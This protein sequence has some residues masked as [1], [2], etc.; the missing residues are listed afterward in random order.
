MNKID[1]S[2]VNDSR[3]K[4]SDFPKSGFDLS[5]NHYRDFI[6]GHLMPAGYQY[7]MPAD[8]FQ[9]SNST[10]YTFNTLV[11]PEIS[12]VQVSQHNF[13]VPF[14]AIDNS[15][16][17]A[18]VPDELNNMSA[19]WRTPL[20]TF[21]QI[22]A[23][24]LTDTPLESFILQYAR[25][26]IPGDRNYQ[27]SDQDELDAVVATFDAWFDSIITNFEFVYAVPFSLQWKEY[28]HNTLLTMPLN[29]A[30]NLDTWVSQVS[31][32][33]DAFLR[34]IIGKG[35]LLDSLGYIYLR[36]YDLPRW[37]SEVYAATVGDGT[38]ASVA[39]F[40]VDLDSTPMC[41]YALRAYYA[42]WYEHYRDPYLQKRSANLPDW[43]DFSSAAIMSDIDMTVPETLYLLLPRIRSWQKDIFVGSMPDDISRHVYA[44]IIYSSHDELVLSDSS[45]YLNA[46]SN[47]SSAP[48]PS[49][50]GLVN[51][52]SYQL[53][54]H[55]P[56]TGSDKSISCP[57]P[58]AVNDSLSTL[59]AN[60]YTA[61][62]FA[63][64]LRDLRKS[65]M[66]ER[67]LK[68]NFYFGDEYQDRMLA[69]YGSKV[70][71][72]SIRR[73]HLLSSS[74][75]TL[76]PKQEVANM[77]NEQTLA[78]TRIATAQDNAGGDAY[79]F[80]A[81]EFGIVINIVSV[82]PKAQYA[83]VCPQNML[84]QQT[85]FPI[86]EFA[87]NNDEFGRNLEIAFSCVL[88]GQQQ[89]QFG[90]YPYAH[91][92]RSRV[93]EV[94][95]SFL[96][97]KSNYTF[98]RFFGVDDAATTPKLNS[99][100]IACVPKLGMFANTNR[101]DGQGYMKCEHT[102]YVERVLPTPVEEI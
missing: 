8:K 94:H 47:A 24:L 78:G 71:D 88:G 86:P 13:Y 98:S 23:H 28:C 52:V 19:S 92:W 30:D 3:V 56:I 53:T 93:D 84:A 12:D 1:R 68:R 42:I 29:D 43:H 55:D 45:Q 90:H 95:G 46:E 102:F 31:V 99:T 49:G 41:E 87:N 36:S 73:P 26:A 80:F 79:E 44:P 27:I 59:S 62:S 75:S 72:N 81:E 58:K 57:L 67:Y 9:G 74:V 35:S 10:R 39:D 82:I 76:N 61:D 21:K 20:F 63:L 40:L 66:L 83:G 34:P 100:F 48:G 7:I 2:N 77:T 91:A 69:H 97:E 33:F 17:R 60:V 96:D 6:M 15:F 70:S 89:Y 38:D 50:P 32:A 22:V 25:Y 11:V 64:D 5:Y 65:Q 37:L 16:E 54:Y 18:M 51:Q 4:A 101:L 85:D 14:R